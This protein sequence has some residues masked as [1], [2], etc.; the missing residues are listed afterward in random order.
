[1]HLQYG[2]QQNWFKHFS[3][4]TYNVKKIKNKSTMLSFSAEGSRGDF[5]GG[6][7]FLQFTALSKRIGSVGLRTSGKKLLSG[8]KPRMW[9][10][11]LSASSWQ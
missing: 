10:F 8:H 9:S 3:F 2:K 4:K 11:D 5:A 6:R 1:M 7:E